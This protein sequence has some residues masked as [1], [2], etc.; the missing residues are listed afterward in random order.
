MSAQAP[1]VSSVVAPTQ[2]FNVHLD[3]ADVDFLKKA[4]DSNER[5]KY[6]QLGEGQTNPYIKIVSALKK[7]LREGTGTA[8]TKPLRTQVQAGP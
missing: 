7:S 1:I 3:L 6:I 5:E 8:L 4:E 2:S